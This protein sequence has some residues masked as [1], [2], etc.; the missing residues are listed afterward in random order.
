M[1][2]KGFLL[3]KNRVWHFSVSSTWQLWSAPMC[4]RGVAETADQQMYANAAAINQQSHPNMGQAAVPQ[5]RK[6]SVGKNLYMLTHT[7]THTHTQTCIHIH[8]QHCT[9]T[10]LN[11]LSAAFSICV[12]VSKRPLYV[13]GASAKTWSYI[14]ML[15]KQSQHLESSHIFNYTSATAVSWPNQSFKTLKCFKINYL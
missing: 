9:D 5:A 15:N 4:V 7:H 12:C 1:R 3:F 13:Q 10:F 2:S 14:K 8:M 6:V 11:F